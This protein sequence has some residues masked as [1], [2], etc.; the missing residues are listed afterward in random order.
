MNVSFRLPTP[1]LDA[2]F[3]KEAAAHGMDG[4]T[5][6]RDA[7]GIRASIYS[8]FPREGCVALAQ[9]M[10]DFAGRNS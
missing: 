1:E 4:L 7:G 3:V 8:A 9:F 6:H 10:R 2:R 5:G